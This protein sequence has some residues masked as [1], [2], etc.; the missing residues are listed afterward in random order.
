MTDSLYLDTAR[1]GLM[2]PGARRASHDLARLAGAEGGSPRFDRLLRHGAGAWPADLRRRYP[3]LAGWQG[4]GRLKESLRTLAGSPPDL[5]VLLA[6]RSAELVRLAA[7]LLFLRSRTVLSTDLGWP[8]YDAILESEARRVGR[9]LARLAVRRAVFEDGLTPGQLAEF[10]ADQAVARRGDALFLP[11]VTSDGVRLPVEAVVRAVEARREL[12]FVAA[13]GAQDFCHVG[14]DLG[15]DYC[16]LYLAGCHKWLGAYHPMGLAFYGR[17]RTRTLIEAT[18]AGLLGSG[19]L[20]DPLLRFSGQLEAGRLDG[21]TETVSLAGLFASQAAADDAAGAWTTGGSAGRA[22]NHR[23][24]AELAPALG[25]Q[26]VLLDPGFRSGILLLRPDRPHLAAAGGEELRSRFL[27]VG[28]ALTAYDGG[29]VRL[30]LPDTPLGSDTISVVRS[31][32]GR[33]AGP[34]DRAAAYGPNGG[35]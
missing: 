7:R 25:W 23:A 33:V 10:V 29:T 20:G 16:D 2:S 28:L 22:D 3:G 18:V 17:R 26:P 19:E 27:D 35:R 15:R 8:A 1:L 5:P 6:N 31:A 11:A 12:T 4:V 34:A 30:S 21:G 14:P 32:L 13:D 9:T 24:V